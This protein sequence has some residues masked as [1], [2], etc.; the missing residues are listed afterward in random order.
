MPHSVSRTWNAAGTGIVDFDTSAF[1][2]APDFTWGTV[3]RNL[4]YMRGPGTDNTDF[5]LQKYFT[6]S[7]RFKVQ[8]RG[9][10]FNV[11]NHPYFTNPDTGYGDSNFGLISG[12]FQPRE[13]Q[14]AIKLLW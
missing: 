12:A 13:I 9:D 11:F 6:V 1:T 7:D 10:A 2:Q 8:V 14:G 5:S 3:T 4:S